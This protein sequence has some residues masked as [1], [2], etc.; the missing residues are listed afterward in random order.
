MYFIFDFDGTLINSLTVS[1]VVFNQLAQQYRFQTIQD[2][3]IESLKELS[4]TELIK[5]LKIPLL[6]IPEIVLRARQQINSQIS[7]LPPFPQ[8]PTVL[9][10]L[11]QLDCQLG[12]LT[13][14][15]RENV[16]IWLHQHEMERLF[17]FIHSESSYFFKHRVLK[18]ILKSHHID[19]SQ[20]VYV[21]DETRDIE[22]AKKNN[23]LSIAV[24]WGV[25][26]E[27]ILLSAKPDYIAHQP[28]DLLAIYR[29]IADRT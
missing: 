18:R 25:A 14:N 15:S 1:I 4:S 9:A 20:A 12:I 8:L 11:R 2:S 27:K 26:S 10:Q 17:S 23:I 24:C 13:S 21:G 22:A 6:K 16:K 29:K 7:H 28:S 19:P 3:E 5:R